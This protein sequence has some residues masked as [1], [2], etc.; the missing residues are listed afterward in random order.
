MNAP[1]A[2]HDAQRGTLP[3]ARVMTPFPAPESNGS[4]SLVRSWREW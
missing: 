1:T 2:I 3:V 4:L